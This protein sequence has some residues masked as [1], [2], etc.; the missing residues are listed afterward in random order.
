MDQHHRLTGAMVLVVDLDIGGVL[1]A[2]SD[3]G[4]QPSSLSTSNLMGRPDGR[5]WLHL[6]ASTPGMVALRMARRARESPWSTRAFLWPSG[7]SQS[8]RRREQ[9]DRGEASFFW[10]GG[11]RYD[12]GPRFGRVKSPR[13]GWRRSRFRSEGVQSLA[14][15]ITRDCF[16]G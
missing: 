16:L 12:K 13:R 8:V 10:W 3:F 9:I 2:D 6:E 5:R 4:H 11:G 1:R 7:S 15:L 14:R